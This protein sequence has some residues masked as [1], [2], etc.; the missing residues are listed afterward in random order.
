MGQTNSIYDARFPFKHIGAMSDDEREARM[1]AFLRRTP[2]NRRT[3]E[4]VKS[5]DGD[6][7]EAA[8]IAK[9]KQ[10]AR[11]A[12]AR[13][14]AQEKRDRERY[15]AWVDRGKPASPTI[16]RKTRM[17]PGAKKRRE[18]ASAL[19]LIGAAQGMQCA[20]C[21]CGMHFSLDQSDGWRATIDHVVP[22][23]LGGG[24][25]RNRVAMHSHC[26]YRKA[27]REPNGCELIW[28]AA[29]NARLTET[30]PPATPLP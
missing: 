26:N 27:N 1:A 13:K 8:R 7:I 10:D 23:S 19:E 16:P 15:Q 17:A 25:D 12:L 5:L 29:V 22:R 20:H 2:R 28:L 9:E 11:N 14:I 6:P 30:A 24:N 18:E 4:L 21:G 3:L